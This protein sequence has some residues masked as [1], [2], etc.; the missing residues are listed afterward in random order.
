[1]GNVP[2]LRHLDVDILNSHRY[3]KK[4]RPEH[5]KLDNLV[6]VN[7]TESQT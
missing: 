4:S 6:D 5:V 3:F 2:N 1:M 7:Y